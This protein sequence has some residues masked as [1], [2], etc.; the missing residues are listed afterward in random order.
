MILY[1]HGFKSTGNARKAGEL[2]EYFQNKIIVE[3]PT[4]DISPEKAIKQLEEIILTNKNIFLIGSSLGGFY[5]MVL[6]AKYNLP[7]VLINPA[8][9]ADESLNSQIGIHKNYDTGEKFEWTTEHIKQLRNLK[10]RYLPKLN[11]NKLFL[12]LAEDDELLDSF[13]TAEK[14]ND[15]A[16]I[17]I[18][19]NTGHQFSRFK[20]MIPEIE[21]FFNI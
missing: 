15:S 4:L 9:N 13:K 21:K 7:A 3:S 19:K 10:K 12:L 20:E 2:K 5:T 17:L 1:I 6:S 11:R 16:K 8:I 14:Y 18:I